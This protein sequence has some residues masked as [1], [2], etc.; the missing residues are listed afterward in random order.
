[1]VSISCSKSDCS[2]SQGVPGAKYVNVSPGWIIGIPQ[3]LVI[4]IRR[5][6]ILQDTMTQLLNVPPTLLRD[7]LRVEFVDEPGIDAGGLVREWSLLVCEALV[8]DSLGIFQ[9]T[10]VDP[11]SY[12][13]N[14]ASGLLNPDHIDVSGVE[15]PSDRY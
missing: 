11:V 2:V 13:I 9:P 5:E 15:P 7:R 14:P 1:M 12:W 8:Q 6:H 10:R 3:H 4:D